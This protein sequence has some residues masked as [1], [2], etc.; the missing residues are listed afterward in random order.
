MLEQ[1]ALL[2]RPCAPSG[3]CVITAGD[4]AVVG[5]AG[6]RH[7]GR[8]WWR[9]L[10]PAVLEVREQE[11]EPLLCTLSRCL[12]LLPWYEVRD[13]EGHRVGRLLG[14]LIEDCHERR[15]AVRRDDPAGTSRFE[16]PD[17]CCLGRLSP[18]AD[19]LCLTFDRAVEQEPFVKM[20][21]LAAALLR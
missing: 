13:A 1:A 15:C 4:G 5:F 17:G 8:R 21:L 14:S 19:G 10:L 16:G 6:W 3:R 18:D 9:R 11:D 12:T 2:L 20:L 7:P